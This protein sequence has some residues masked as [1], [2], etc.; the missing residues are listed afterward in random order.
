MNGI[1]NNYNDDNVTYHMCPFVSHPLE[2][3]YC[4]EMQSYRIE[5]VLYYCAN[6]YEQCSTYIN[7]CNK[8][9]TVSEQ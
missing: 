6:N 4:S 1:E 3:C 8:N 7:N 2:E 9:M 5:S